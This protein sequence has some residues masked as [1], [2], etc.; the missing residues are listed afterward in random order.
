MKLQDENLHF[1][2]FIIKRQGKHLSW[3]R[4]NACLEILKHEGMFVLLSETLVSTQKI[5]TGWKHFIPA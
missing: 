2:L 1:F 4:D 5:Y 3:F